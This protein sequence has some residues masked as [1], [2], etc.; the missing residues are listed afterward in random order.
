MST[1]NQRI[2]NDYELAMAY[3]DVLIDTLD[4]LRDL[5]RERVSKQ[6]LD[7]IINSTEAELKKLDLNRTEGE[8]TQQR[9]VS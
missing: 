5:H 7:H 9:K 6:V 8:R 2:R 1:S 3:R 4:Q